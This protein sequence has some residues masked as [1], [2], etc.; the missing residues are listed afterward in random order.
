V[1]PLGLGDRAFDRYM[2]Y[3]SIVVSVLLLG[4]GFGIRGA[5]DYKDGVVG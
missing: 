2:I 3:F 5:G 1:G 4:V